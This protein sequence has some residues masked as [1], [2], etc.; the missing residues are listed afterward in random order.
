MAPQLQWLSRNANPSTRS[1]RHFRSRAW[2]RFLEAGSVWGATPDAMTRSQ[3]TVYGVDSVPEPIAAC[4]TTR[5]QYQRFLAA[6]WT[7]CSSFLERPAVPESPATGGG[8]IVARCSVILRLAEPL[9]WLP[10][11]PADGGEMGA[12]G[13]RRRGRAR[14]YAC[15]RCK[16]PETLPNYAT[17]A[18]AQKVPS[19]RDFTSRTRLR[20]L[21]YGRQRSRMVCGLVRPSSTTSTRWRYATHRSRAAQR[22]PERA[23]RGGSWRHHIK[24][25]RCSARSSIPPEFKCYADY[26]FRV[27]PAGAI[28][29]SPLLP[30]DEPRRFP[31][32]QRRGI[33]T[34]QLRVVSMLL[35]RCTHAHS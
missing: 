14:S 35:V 3:S 15:G 12:R 29:A 28:R 21:R 19:P 33:A 10:I 23:S 25:S 30:S 24:V 32:A 18:G 5:G 4:Q 13:A 7:A 2:F 9:I 31:E 34:Y 20:T 11:L 16:A 22:W 1:V 27:A 17:R 6:T 8:N 26:S